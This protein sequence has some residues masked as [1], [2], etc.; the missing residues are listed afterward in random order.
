MKTKLL[1]RLR[2]IANHSY[3]IAPAPEGFDWYE[4][5]EYVS[6]GWEG[7]WYSRVI[8]YENK[9][10]EMLEKKLQELRRKKF[11]KLCLEA[12]YERRLEKS[13]KL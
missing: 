13:S 3:R 8:S 12:V 5:Q 2:S 9:K 11:H 1:R 10:P 6:N 4:I 7:D